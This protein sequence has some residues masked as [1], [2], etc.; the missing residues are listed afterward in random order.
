MRPREGWL[1]LALLVVMLLSV[2]W[3][4]QRTEWIPQTEFLVPIAVL[5]AILGALLGLTRLSVL[6]VI[7][8]AAL[9]GTGLLV[10]AIGGEYFPEASQT[11]RLLLLRTETVDWMRILLDRGYGPQLVPYAMAF[12]LVMW[13]TAF[14][15]AYAI[16]RHHRVLDAILVVGVAIIANM[17]STVTDLFG[18]L[19]LFMLA[20]LLLWLRAALIGREEGWQRRRV[21]ENVEVPAAIMRSGVV[22]IGLSIALAWVLTTVAVAAPL[23]AVWNNLDGVWR[24]ARDRLDGIL[25]GLSNPE[26]RFQGPTFGNGFRI[27]GN[28]V[29]S[30]EPVLTIA[31]PRSYYLRTATY[32]RYTGHGFARSAVE[33]RNVVA[34]ELLFPDATPEEPL[35]RDAFDLQ[36]VTIV[37]SRSLGGA[38]FTPGYPVTVTVPAVVLETGGSPVLGGLE[39]SSSVPAGTGYAVTALIS[40]ATKAQLN[41]AGQDYPEAIEELY[42]GTEGV[43][44]QTRQLALDLV[45]RANAQTPFEQAEALA[46]FLRTDDSFRYQTNAPVPGDPDADIVDFFLFDTEDGRV[47]YCEYYATAMAV[48]ARTLGLPARVAVGYAPGE[49]ISAAEG[50]PESRSY[51]VREGN[52]HAWAEVYF[53]GYGWERFE[54]TKTIAPVTRLQGSEEGPAPSGGPRPSIPLRLGPNDRGDVF[55]LP[56]F[57]PAPGGFG[58]TDEGPPPESRGGNLLLIVGIVVAALGVAAWRLRLTRRRIR[59]LA[60]GERQW[61][62][63]ALAA[64]RAGV[65]QRPTETIY[66]YASWLE[67]Q[68]PRHRPDIQTIA[69]G[70][71]WQSYSGRSISGEALALIERAWKSLELPMLWLAVRRRVTGLIPAFRRKGQ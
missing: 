17:S 24:D 59:F 16:Y 27:D 12:G 34:G 23:T 15:A 71:V 4:V 67:E 28:F 51:L 31:S 46:E 6:A 37:H 36:T 35:N 38:I 44:T 52:A 20:A 5:G 3:S 66:E 63:L 41:A 9:V 29:S 56:S 39:S 26:A 10:W 42:L 2:G 13:V 50:A 43:T 33:E 11:E 14:M 70:K 45:R 49:A 22:F 65:G 64:D 25:G 8:I 21:N 7:P 47:G 68:I 53:P 30:A 19:V 57:Q 69:R 1:S 62:R 60:P 40:Q 58:P 55:N 32:D 18:Y 48:M 54:A 61:F